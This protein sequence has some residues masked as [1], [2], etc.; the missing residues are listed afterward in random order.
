MPFLT[1]HNSQLTPPPEV[2]LGILKSSCSEFPLV[3]RFNPE[4][5]SLNA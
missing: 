4:A 1:P 2:T 5:L 3:H